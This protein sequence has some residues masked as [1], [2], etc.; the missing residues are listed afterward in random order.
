VYKKSYSRQSE[1]VFAVN[2]YIACYGY[3]VIDIIFKS[4]VYLYCIS[5]YLSDFLC[6]FVITRAIALSIIKI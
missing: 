3:N 6:N 4:S 5:K 2:K 1:A